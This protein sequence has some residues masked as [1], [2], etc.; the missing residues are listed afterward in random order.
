M[1]HVDSNEQ[2]ADDGDIFNAEEVMSDSESEGS[3]DEASYDGQLGEV[4][5]KG[6]VEQEEDAGSVGSGTGM[7]SDQN[8]RDTLVL[9]P[10]LTEDDF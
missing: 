6:K 7:G 3:F 4:T 9:L 5:Y 10:T 1:E 8:I 2:D